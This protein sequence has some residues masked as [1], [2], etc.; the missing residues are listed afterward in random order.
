MI[1]YFQRRIKFFLL[2][3]YLC[4][5][6][7]LSSNENEE[8]IQ[9]ENPN[10]IIQ[11]N[12]VDDSIK[13]EIKN[14]S[15]VFE[16]NI[17]ENK[18]LQI[19]ILKN[20]EAFIIDEEKIQKIPLIYNINP[21]GLQ[22][23][24]MEEEIIIISKIP[25][26]NTLQKQIFS[27]KKE[28]I[29]VLGTSSED[30]TGNYFQNL[31]EYAKKG[32]KDIIL[33]E[34]LK[35]VKY[36]YQ[37]VNGNE[38]DKFSKEIIEIANTKELNQ[39]IKIYHSFGILTAKLIL[40]YYSNKKNLEEIDLEDYKLWIQLWEEIGWESYELFLFEYGK[41][42]L[43]KNSELGEKILEELIAKKPNFFDAYIALGNY[44]WE[45]NKKIKAYSLYKKA[46]GSNQKNFQE[47]F[48]ILVPEYIMERVKSM[49]K[50]IENK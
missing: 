28:K 3:L 50:V 38:F 2:I 14:N 31:F 37:Y 8:I 29:E 35:D 25:F 26:S 44:Y 7:S 30:L 47:N 42:Y 17:K 4:I 12:L 45:R 39:K 18:V 34:Q 15:T 24:C 19:A 16:C 23:S 32:S 11:D 27:L 20:G 1:N 5:A 48:T 9:E 13:E 10:I 43:A 41:T 40:Y 49:D 22:I 21:E 36:S 46:I 33:K 6:N